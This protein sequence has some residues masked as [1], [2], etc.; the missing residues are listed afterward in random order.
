MR[1]SINVRP[2]RTH[3]TDMTQEATTNQ[4]C[5]C[6]CSYQSNQTKSNQKTKTNER[7]THTEAPITGP[8]AS[9]LGGSPTKSTTP[10]SSMLSGTLLIV[11]I[12]S[13]ISL[14]LLNVLIIGCCL[15][16][17]SSKRIKRGNIWTEPIA[18]RQRAKAFCV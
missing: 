17:R 9:S 13:G 4:N 16:K 18:R 8:P 14:V 5:L 6:F 1:K 2:L 3:V 12:A 10:V 7:T 15:R 11:G